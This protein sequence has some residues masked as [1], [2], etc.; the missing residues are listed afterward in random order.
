MLVYT[1]VLF[2]PPPA[3]DECQVE[4]S[5]TLPRHSNCV[6]IKIAKPFSSQLTPLVLSK[7]TWSTT[8]S[9]A[10]G[11]WNY[12]YYTCMHIHYHSSSIL[13][14]LPFQ[15]HLGGLYF[16]TCIVYRF[17]S[18]RVSVVLHISTCMVYR[19]LSTWV[20][21][22]FNHQPWKLPFDSGHVSLWFNWW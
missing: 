1:C 21:V 22:V 10:N 18:M 19:V 16:S 20:S 12:H 8:F 6:V 17:R 3:L 4:E 9:L 5:W 7:S 13:H 2:P 14:T 15:L 11:T